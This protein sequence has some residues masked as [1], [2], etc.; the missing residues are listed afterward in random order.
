MKEDS[1][2]GEIDEKTIEEHIKKKYSNINDQLILKVTCRSG[3]HG[4]SC[5][6]NIIRGYPCEDIYAVQY[7]E[8]AERS[9]F[10]DAVAGHS[11]SDGDPVVWSDRGQGTVR[12][13]GH[14]EIAIGRV[15]R[16]S[17]G[18][19]VQVQLFY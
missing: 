7:F 14:G 18:E 1:V 15:T 16:A 11:M 17:A 19:L 13:A 3:I 12:L 6:W 2:Q 8:M 10:I 4:C 9:R 5:S